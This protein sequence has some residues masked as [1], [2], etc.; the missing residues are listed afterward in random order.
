MGI[1]SGKGGDVWSTG[2]WAETISLVSGT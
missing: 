1:V 2:L